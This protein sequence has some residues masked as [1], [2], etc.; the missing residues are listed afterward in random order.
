MML[1]DSGQ[2]SW[3]QQTTP[4]NLKL[5]LLHLTLVLAKNLVSEEPPIDDDIKVFLCKN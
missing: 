1:H 2:V 4:N 5:H 3:A